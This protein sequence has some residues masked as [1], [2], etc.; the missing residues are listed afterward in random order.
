MKKAVVATEVR[1]VWDAWVAVLRS[2]SVP[3]DTASGKLDLCCIGGKA[4]AWIQK[5]R[6]ASF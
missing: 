6:I 3:V 1:G 2:R 4:E 5:P